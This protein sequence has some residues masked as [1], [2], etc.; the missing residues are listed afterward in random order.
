MF[1]FDRTHVRR[2]SFARL[3]A[4]LPGLAALAI[5]CLMLGL[6]FPERPSRAA[7]VPRES[8][9]QG[10]LRGHV[11][12]TGGQEVLA[13]LTEARTKAMKAKGRDAAHCLKGKPFEMQQQTYYV[14]KN[15]WVGNVFV[16]VEPAEKGQFF[17]I[18]SEQAD[19]YKDKVVVSQPHCTFIP[20]CI[21]MFPEYKD[22]EGKFHRTGQKLEI[23]NDAII[24]H[25]AK[26]EGS[27]FN[28]YAPPT[29]EPGKNTGALEI[30]VEKGPFF[31]S[32]GIHTWMKAVGR[33]FNHPYATLT[34]VPY[35]KDDKDAYVGVDFAARD[36]GSY[37]LEV[38]PGVKLRLFVWHEEAGFLNEGGRKGQ[39][40]E[41]RK[42]VSKVMNFEMAAR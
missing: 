24:A 26:V 36:F 5:G 30:K 41:L 10:V 14:G 4:G 8:T 23:I 3:K 16:W 40:I 13:K 7:P 21:V 25:N 32:C 18:T 27:L 39:E 38:P 6:S 31:V 28:K 29:L 35:Q 2:R 11:K 15:G 9:T 22:K 17:P 37:K 42:G 34:K 33:A 20:H 19:K 1:V 12:F